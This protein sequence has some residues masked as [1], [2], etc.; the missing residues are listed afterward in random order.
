[1]D[2]IRTRDRRRGR[3]ERG[4]EGIVGTGGPFRVLKE[5]SD[6]RKTRGRGKEVGLLVRR[7]GKTMESG[8]G[9]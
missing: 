8:Q 5:D 9:V 4:R 1:M 6:G 2:Q 3:H 7:R